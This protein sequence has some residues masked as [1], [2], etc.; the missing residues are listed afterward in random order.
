MTEDLPK[1]DTIASVEHIIYLFALGKAEDNRQKVS[2]N[3]NKSLVPNITNTE[4]APLKS[5]HQ[6]AKIAILIPLRK[7]MQQYY[8]L[9]E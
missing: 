5:L 1:S 3:I 7:E 9:L 2:L 8:C 6:N 4:S